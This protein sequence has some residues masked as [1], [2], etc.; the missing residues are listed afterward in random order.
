MTTMRP[1]AVAVTS[2]TPGCYASTTIGRC[3]RTDPGCIRCR[4]PGAPLGA[5]T[6]SGQRR[7]IKCVSAP[8]PVPPDSGPAPSRLRSAS[9]FVELEDLGSVLDDVSVQ[10]LLAF[11]VFPDP[12]RLQRVV[13]CYRTETTWTLFGCRDGASLIGC[14]GIQLEAAG[15]AVIRH[16]AVLPNEQRRQVGRT[17]IAAVI[18]RHNLVRLE[19]ETD[20]DSVGF[21]QRCGFTIESLGERFPGRERFRCVYGSATPKSMTSA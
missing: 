17:L 7:Y 3:A 15:C 9:V 14:V 16:I 10:N 5:A 19:A 6:A 4:A 21:Y 13:D 1:R 2:F 11:A 12:A 8:T 20:T 18:A